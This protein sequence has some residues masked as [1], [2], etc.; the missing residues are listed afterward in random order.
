MLAQGPIIT[1]PEIDLA[2]ATLPAAAQPVAKGT[3]AESLRNM[4]RKHI[5]GILKQHSWNISR[6]AKALGIDRVTLYNK[7]KKYQIRED[8]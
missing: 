2:Q 8:E 7:I 1:P 4:E 3:A 6:S 5:V